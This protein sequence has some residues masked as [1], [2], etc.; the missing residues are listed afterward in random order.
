MSKVSKRVFKNIL[1]D[2]FKRKILVNLYNKWVDYDN[3]ES[4]FKEVFSNFDYFVSPIKITKDEETNKE[5]LV[6]EYE[7]DVK[8]LSVNTAMNAT[9]YGC[10]YLLVRLMRNFY[11]QRLHSKNDK[12][13]T[14][15]WYWY[16]NRY[17]IQYYKSLNEVNKY[18]WAYI[19]T[20]NRNKDYRYQMIPCYYILMTHTCKL[21]NDESFELYN[22]FECT[23][24]FFIK[25]ISSFYDILI[26]EEDVLKD[27]V[28][29]TEP[30][31]TNN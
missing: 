15:P 7:N 10:L 19:F 4:I 13:Y 12:K 2:N 20:K 29:I 6:Y 25:C 24:E 31:T 11:G 22:Q 17:I 27:L 1:N 3:P 14:K 28:E 16:H 18:R 5:I 26:K 30:T 8:P 9:P 21:M 23:N